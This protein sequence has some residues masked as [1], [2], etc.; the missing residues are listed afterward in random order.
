MDGNVKQM[1]DN[2]PLM[3]DVF[4][5]APLPAY[6]PK[7]TIARLKAG[8]LHLSTGLNDVLLKKVWFR[9]VE[10]DLFAVMRS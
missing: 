8:Q 2:P 1:A 6:A 9:L 3:K 10:C 4:I 7:A 5:Y